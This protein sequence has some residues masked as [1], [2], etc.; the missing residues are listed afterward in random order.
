ME[1]VEVEGVLLEVKGWRLR[2]CN[3]RLR[4]RD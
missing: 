1:D 4:G 3:L 2:E